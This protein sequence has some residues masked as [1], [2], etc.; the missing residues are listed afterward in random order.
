MFLTAASLLQNQSDPSPRIFCVG[1]S[2]THG[3]ATP[4]EG[5]FPGL[6]K[7]LLDYNQKKASVYNCGVSG[8][9]SVATNFFVKNIL[10]R[11]NPQCIIIHDGYNDL[12]IAITKTGEDE[13]LYIT[14]DYQKPYNPYIN[15][16]LAR[17][18]SSFIKINFPMTRQFLLETMKKTMHN[19]KDLFLG[20]DS[21][22]Y[23]R[24][25]GP[26]IKVAQEN[27]L[28][29]KIMVEKEID[30]I[31]YCLAHHIKVIVILEPRIYSFHFIPPFTSG[32]RDQN[33]APLLAECHKVQQAIY[34]QLIR[35]RYAGNN[36]VAV[37]DM[38]RVFDDSYSW[39]FYDECHL[40][41][42]G[43]AIKAQLLYNA[44]QKLFPE[45]S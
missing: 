19:Q 45:L 38:S 22:K 42:P 21:T 6:L 24:M 3:C 14:P 35:Q 41:T 37:V 2:T 17:Y 44:L 39:L 20:F 16:P 43:N 10:S 30:T 29:I 26:G 11:Y 34:S 33:V 25:K 36:N 32:F 15:N 4:L 31:D 28:R 7:S 40:T 27:S 12:P 1:G 9:N 23:P 8:V 13:Y 5:S 18:C